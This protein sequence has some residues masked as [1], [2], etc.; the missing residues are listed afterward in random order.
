MATLPLQKRHARPDVRVVGKFPTE[1]PRLDFQQPSLRPSSVR[2]FEL[3]RRRSRCTT[4]G[5]AVVFSDQAAAIS[6]PSGVAREGLRHCRV[7][8]LSATRTDA[9]P[10]HAEPPLRCPARPLRTIP[11]AIRDALERRFAQTGGRQFS[12]EN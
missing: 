7:A 2:G 8:D 6:R 11:D 9:R 3:G 10:S 1:A 12:V 4:N 5:R